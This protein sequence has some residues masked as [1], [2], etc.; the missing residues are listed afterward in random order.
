MAY[1]HA[2]ANVCRAGVT[3]AGLANHPAVFTVGATA[4]TGNVLVDDFTITT[5]LD[6]A[7]SS[8]QFT[9]QGF[10]P[11]VGND[12][13][14]TMGGEL[15][16]GGTILSS[17]AVMQK[18]NSG[19][20]YWNCQAIDWTWEMDRESPV[21]ILIQSSLGVNTI[22]ALL[23]RTYTDPSSGFTPGYISSA[24]GNAGPFAWTGMKVSEALRA[25]A[26]SAGCYMRITPTKAVDMFTSLPASNALSLGNSSEI[27][28][29]VY[30]QSLSQ[31]RTK[32]FIAGGGGQTTANVSVGATVVPVDECEWYTGTVAE[33]PGDRFVYTGRSASSG[34]GNL[35][36]CSGVAYDIPQGT[37]VRV[38]GRVT[39]T[40]AETALATVLGGGTG[41]AF[42]WFDG[43]DHTQATVTAMA[44]SDT[45]LYGAALPSLQYTTAARFHEPGKEVTV[46]ISDPV[47]VSGT[48][49]IQSVTMRPFGAIVGNTPRFEY[50]VQCRLVRRQDA[51]DV[52]RKV[53]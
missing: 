20:V 52:L 48:F 41:R 45:T 46:S 17:R 28:Q 4:R 47:S 11:A 24:V 51:I 23:L 37:K 43:G 8:C 22:T 53:G 31:V 32:T 42:G 12:V 1:Y 36:G 2:R 21:D 34:P 16:W 33:T 35:T 6:N 25:V 50:A 9:V 14:L 40:A 5:T 18:F 29:A 30:E 13:T 38:V 19:A 44:T 10:T 3:H 15:V 7:P 49:R 27:R 26:A 39:N